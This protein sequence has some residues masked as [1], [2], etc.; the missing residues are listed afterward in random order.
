VRL[1]ITSSGTGTTR[2]TKSVT[3][4]TATVDSGGSVT[5]RAGGTIVR[6]GSSVSTRQS[7]IYFDSSSANSA[8]MDIYS[9][10]ASWADYGLLSKVKLRAGNLAGIT[11]GIYGALSGDGI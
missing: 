4:Y 6:V 8:Y 9:G 3:S 1:V 5:M 2:N 10:V 7:S 11:S